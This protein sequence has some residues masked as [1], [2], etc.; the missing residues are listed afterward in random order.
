MLIIIKHL[1]WNKNN[2]LDGWTVLKTIN[3]LKQLE[4]PKKIFLETIFQTFHHEI[5]NG[6]SSRVFDL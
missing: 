4:V 3:I 6:E 1:P 5:R 2:L